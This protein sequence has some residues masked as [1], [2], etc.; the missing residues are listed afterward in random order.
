M[1][2][3]KRLIDSLGFPLIAAVVVGYGAPAEA[4]PKVISDKISVSVPAKASTQVQV[5]P[6]APVTLGPTTSSTNARSK[7]AAAKPESFAQVYRAGTGGKW[8]RTLVNEVRLLPVL[9]ESTTTD[10]RSYPLTDKAGKTFEDYWYE[11]SDGSHSKFIVSDSDRVIGLLTVSDEAGFNIQLDVNGDRTVDVGIALNLDA[12]ETIYLHG[13]AGRDFVRQTMEGFDPICEL[14]GERRTNSL[15]V[16]DACPDYTSDAA[17]AGGISPGRSSGSPSINPFGSWSSPIDDLCAGVQASSRIHGY[18]AGGFLEDLY[19]G[20]K[21]FIHEGFDGVEDGNG[22]KFGRTMLSVPVL[23][24]TLIPAYG[25][26]FLITEPAEAYTEGRP[27]HPLVNPIA[28][29]TGAVGGLVGNGQ[30]AADGGDEET[31]DNADADAADADDENA[32]EAQPAATP[33]EE[34]AEPEADQGDNASQPIEKGNG[35]LEYCR[36]RAASREFWFRQSGTKAVETDCVDAVINPA[37]TR[38]SAT[39]SPTTTLSCLNGRDEAPAT[40]DATLSGEQTCRHRAVSTSGAC[41]SDLVGS[42]AKVSYGFG[43]TLNIKL[44]DIACPPSVCS[45]APIR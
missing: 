27:V 44:G 21:S 22:E 31:Q 4:S 26:D 6:T 1:D 30:N 38:A 10:L 20:V 39:G 24:V 11:H 5:R 16:F 33:E 41:P 45:G 25:L 13:E 28:T 29:V 43:D 3:Y 8:R 15:A 34:A 7:P 35:L 32:A 40:Q 9:E 23:M 37:P 2:H 19:N 42:N 36:E 17:A 12:Q 14:S 18:A